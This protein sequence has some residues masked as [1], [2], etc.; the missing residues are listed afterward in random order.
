[1]SE[2]GPT[3]YYTTMPRRRGER[4]GEGGAASRLYDI[5]IYLP[6]SYLAIYLSIYLSLPSP[7]PGRGGVTTYY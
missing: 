4:A 6:I 5:A 1:M 2:V 3:L 7:T